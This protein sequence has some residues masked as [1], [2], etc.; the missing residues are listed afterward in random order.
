[1]KLLIL[2]T[3][4]IASL[5]VF[6]AELGEDQKSECA[7]ANQTTKREAKPSLAVG[8]EST[9]PVSTKAISK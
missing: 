8:T 4:S 5:N 2:I 7:Y 1:M 9:K 3:I 6:S